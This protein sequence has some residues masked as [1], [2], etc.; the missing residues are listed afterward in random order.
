MNVSEPNITTS[1]DPLIGKQLGDYRITSRLASGGMARV[2]KGM[3]YKLQRPAAIKVLD[4]HNVDLEATSTARFKRE[5]RAVA[6]LEHPNIIPIYQYGEDESE[7]VYFLA[8]KLVKGHDLADELRRLKR[9]KDKLMPIDRALKI[10]TQVAS[11]LDY[12]HSQDII[13]RDVKPSNILIDKDD[14]ATLTDMGLVLRVSAETT[15]GTAF[16]TPRYI[17]PEQATSS[18]K[19]VPQSDIYSYAVILYE[20]LTG[21]TPFDGGTPMEIALA[22]ISEP[23]PSPRTVNPG[24]PLVVERELMRALDKDPAK[25]HKSATQLIEAVKR[26]YNT[27]AASALSIAEPL[28]EEATLALAP[29][30]DLPAIEIENKSRRLPVPMLLLVA[31]ALL[32]AGAFIVNGLADMTGGQAAADGAPVLLIYDESTFTFINEGDY[33]LN[34]QDLKFIRGV[35]D[36]VDDF[37]GDRI[38]RDV[39]PSGQNCFQIILNNTTPTVPPQCNP[40]SQHRHGQEMLSNP[41]RVHWRAETETSTRVKTFEVRYKGQLLARC[42]TIERGGFGECRLN[43]P[44]VPP[45]PEA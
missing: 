18:D 12:A 15:M 6:A 44:E 45:T 16:G 8:M 27:P 5:A 9:S 14:H 4:T 10:M 11:A 13:H 30:A 43:W 22:H 17:A 19:A 20:I 37:S 26:G 23:A 25:R 40:I 1:K 3:D 39:L 32:I 28:N 2:Y 24:I 36:N 38:P 29:A 41:L 31:V 34:V 33:D 42:D 21:Q 7:G 35:D